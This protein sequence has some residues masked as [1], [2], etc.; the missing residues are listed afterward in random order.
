MY[1]YCSA[2]ESRA[3]AK[4]VTVC[5]LAEPRQ[6]Q[7]TGD[8]RKS[9]A[10]QKRTEAETG[11]RLGASRLADCRTLGSTVVDPSL[12]EGRRRWASRFWS[13]LTWGISEKL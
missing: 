11:S 5:S 8:R 3:K 4:V 2:K 1:S 6:C 9:S 10:T 13:D 7:E 12:R